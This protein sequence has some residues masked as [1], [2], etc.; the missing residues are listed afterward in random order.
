MMPEWRAVD[1]N[2][3]GATTL[4]A[5]TPEALASVASGDDFHLAP[6]REDGVTPGTP[7]RVWSVVVDDHVYVRSAT[8][9]SRWFAAA[10]RERG[11]MVRTNQY[12]GKVTFDLVEDEAL[13]DRVDDAYSAKYANDTYLSADLLKRS[14][15]Q[16]ARVGPAANAS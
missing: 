1:Q 3:K 15:H 12:S 13:K 2:G 7:I 8:P 6:Y 5:W 4:S 9:G 11:G 16:I 10:I 14:R